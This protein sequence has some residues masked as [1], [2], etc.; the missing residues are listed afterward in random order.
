LG[1]FGIIKSVTLSV[2]EYAKSKNITIHFECQIPYLT[3]KCDAEKIER[4]LLNLLSNA[5]K[6]NREGG[7]VVVSISRTRKNLCFCVSDDGPGIPNSKLEMIFERFR[8]VDSGL[9]KEGEGSG[10]GLSLVKSL[11][12]MHGGSISVKSVLNKGTQFI[13]ELPIKKDEDNS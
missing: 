6:F 13:M 3:M 8:Q 7:C 10:I 2:A 12:E 5:I 4:I 1:Y 9:T 11:I